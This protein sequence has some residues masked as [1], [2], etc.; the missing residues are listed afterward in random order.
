[1]CTVAVSGST[2]RGALASHSPSLKDMALHIAANFM[3]GRQNQATLT[4]SYVS[5]ALMWAL[6]QDLESFLLEL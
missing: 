5:T 3:Y 6:Q 2:L 4:H 1:M